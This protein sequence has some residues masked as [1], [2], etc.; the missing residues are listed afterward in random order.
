M[1]YCADISKLTTDLA[2]WQP[3]LSDSRIQKIKQ[4]KT[5]EQAKQCLGVELLLCYAM[6]QEYSTTQFP[7]VYKRQGN[8]KPYFETD[9]IYFSLSHSGRYVACAVSNMPIGVD[10]Q[11]HNTANKQTI[12]KV[13]TKNQLDMIKLLPPAKQ[14]T[15]LYDFWTLKESIY[16]CTGEGS[17][18]T[19]IEFEFHNAGGR[20]G[21][22]YKDYNLNYYNILPNCSLG[23]CSAAPLSPY[24][25]NLSIDQIKNKLIEK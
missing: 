11:T 6:N 8:G 7:L 4:C 16:K 19:P 18:R 25:F 9:E 3:L 10:L 12:E 23:V 17:V 21:I 13:L 5:D 22:T 14:K 2:T 1:I 15:A 20:L 24:I